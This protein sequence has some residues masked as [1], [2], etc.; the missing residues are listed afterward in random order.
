MSGFLRDKLPA[1]KYGWKIS[2]EDSIGDFDDARF[3]GNTYYVKKAADAD[4][5]AFI[6]AHQ[7]TY[8]DGTV[9]VYTTAD[10]VFAAASANDRIIFMK[11]DSGG[12]DLTAT[13]EITQRGLKVFG[14][15]NSMYSQDT[16]IKLPATATDVDMFLVKTDKVEFAGLT[17][18]NR[19][20]GKCIAIGDTAGQAYYQIH[21][22]DC[23]FTDY[24]GVATYGVAPGNANEANNSHVD[25]VNL[26]VERCTFDGF[27]TAAIVAN[28]TRDCYQDNFIRLPASGIGILMDKHTD[29]RGYGMIRGNYILGTGTTDY[30]IKV[31][32]TDSAAG[33][34]CI[35]ENIIQGCNTT[36]TTQANLQ[37]FDNNSAAAAT[38]AK[39]AIDIVT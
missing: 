33:L 27:V 34:V 39:T 21:I 22:H 7:Q 35:A 15:G 4:Y 26:V 1:L 24:G 32:D 30:G 9:A 38:G 6:A 31:T 28:G 14:C 3:M 5:D 23:N 29:S 17:F 20:A 10:L 37:G 16:T 36:I 18:Q 25:P 11:P 12:H 19:K 13:I 2:K 8:T